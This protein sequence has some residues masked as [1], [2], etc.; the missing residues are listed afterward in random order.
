MKVVTVTYC[1]TKTKAEKAVKA[2][3]IAFYKGKYFAGKVVPKKKAAAKH[4]KKK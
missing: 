1:D 3:R 4:K 2:G